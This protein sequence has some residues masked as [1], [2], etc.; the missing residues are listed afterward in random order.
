MIVVCPSCATRQEVEENHLIQGKA[1]VRCLACRRRWIERTQGQVI[2]AVAC[3]ALPI[4]GPEA[5]NTFHAEREATRL[6]Q[7]ARAA[8]ERY[9]G[10][11]RQ[12]AHALRRWLALAAA[13]LA[14]VLVMLLLPQQVARAFP[15]AI[16]L[17]AIAGLD[18]NLR[19]LEFR[20]VG[21]QHLFTDNVRV[22]AIQGEIVNVSGSD[23]HIPVIQFTLRDS[24]KAAIYEWKLNPATRPIRA[25]E[26]STFLTRLASPPEAAEGVEIRFAAAG[27]SG[28]TP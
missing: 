24:R 8:E 14:P 18:I 2:E 26:S 22:L 23:R 16:R 4:P 15:P 28:T 21:Q 12:R 13:V 25:G 1:L 9:R 20:N 11:Q 3:E 5:Q 6:T 19:G 27:D 17:Y 7:A 10:Q